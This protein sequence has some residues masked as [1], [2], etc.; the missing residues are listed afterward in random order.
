M[1]DASKLDYD[2]NVAAT[3]AAAEWAH[4]HGLCLEAELGEV[5]GKDGAHAPGVRTDPGEAA[6][7]VAATGVDAL[8]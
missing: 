4:Q 1:F 3:K 5:G 6:A 8:A 2:A 7:F